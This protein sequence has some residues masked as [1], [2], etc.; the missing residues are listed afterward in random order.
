METFTTQDGTIIT[1]N[2]GNVDI[3]KKIS[4][5][6]EFG[7]TYWHIDSCLDKCFS[8]W[9]DDEIDEDR[10]NAGNYFL[11]E[12]EC[13]AKIEY[14]IALAIV[15]RAIKKLNGS[16]KPDWSDDREAGFHFWYN[17]TQ[18]KFEVLLTQAKELH[19]IPYCKSAEIANQI[20]ANYEKEL[21]II[22]DYQF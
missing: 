3:Q 6:P 18:E 20:I 5:M 10:Y 4:D 13:D 7:S 16:W 2:N 12:A 1:Y 8:D 19:S 17:Y 14:D 15:R 22:R 9:E 11:T 21:C